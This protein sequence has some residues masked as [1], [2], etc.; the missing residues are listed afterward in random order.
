MQSDSTVPKYIPEL[1]G[2]RALAILLV[3]FV[4]DYRRF[5]AV[6]LEGFA[7]H[8]WI[9]VDLFFVLSGFLI[10]RI[11]LDS[12]KNEGYFSSFYA[13]RA[14]RIWPLYWIILI[15]AFPLYSVVQAFL[16]LGGTERQWWVYL[17][18]VQNLVYPD[19]LGPRILTATWSLAIEEQFYLL[20]PLM[21]RFIRV[22]ALVWVLSGML[23]FTAGLRWLAHVRGVS[24]I[25]IF[26]STPCRLDGL[27]LGSLLAIWIGS[28]TFSMSKLRWGSAITLVAGLA[29]TVWLIPTNGMDDS[30]PALSFTVLAVMFVGFVG[31]VIGW[32]GTQMPLANAMRSRALREVGKVSYCMYLVHLPVF[33]FFTGAN[34]ARLTRMSLGRWTG[35]A[36]FPIECATAFGVASLSWRFFEK[37]ILSLKSRF[38]SSPAKAVPEIEVNVA[39]A[40]A[41]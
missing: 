4:H 2:V 39:A 19:G 20:W 7:V 38:E 11:L 27:A 5:E 23:I 16:H 3:M 26:Q 15:L 40:T 8:G 35:L 6:H 24:G 12:R 10:T 9:G 30:A 13:R 14:L 21:V 34:F 41:D 29:G 25:A 37:P 18:L 31:L 28:R 22:R 17:L 1:D 36:M 32:T 33:G